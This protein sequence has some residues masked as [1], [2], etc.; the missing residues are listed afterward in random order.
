MKGTGATNAKIVQCMHLDTTFPLSE[1]SPFKGAQTK[2]YCRRIKGIDVSVQLEDV[3]DSTSLGFC[4]DLIGKFLEDAIIALAAYTKLQF[5]DERCTG[6]LAETL[7]RYC[8]LD[9]MSMVFIWEY[10]MEVTN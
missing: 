5:S 3:N 7:L 1:Q 9:T 4:D 6:A 10:F 8:E 2:V